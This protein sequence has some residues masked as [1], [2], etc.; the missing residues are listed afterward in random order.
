M[1]QSDW[2]Y[3]INYLDLITPWFIQHVAW[4]TQCSSTARL[5][6]NKFKS[7]THHRECLFAIFCDG[8][9]GKNTRLEAVLE[10]EGGAFARF[11]VEWDRLQ[12][13]HVEESLVLD[14][15]DAR[16]VKVLAVHERPLLRK[17]TL[18]VGGSAACFVGGG[19]LRR[20]LTAAVATHASIVVVFVISL[21]CTGK[22]AFASVDAFVWVVNF[23]FSCELIKFA[24]L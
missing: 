7:I 22:C 8:H 18:V 21:G 20:H 13:A 1:K 10:H 15:R 12:T 23:V 2:T 14:A 19:L 3:Y 16:M 9:H 24:L 17:V 11:K 4:I 5:L 6:L